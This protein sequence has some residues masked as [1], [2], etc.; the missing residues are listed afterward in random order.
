M[1]ARH[2]R[3]AASLLPGPHRQALPGDGALRVE[4]WYPDRLPREA[5]PTT[6]LFAGVWLV[7]FLSAAASV[8]VGRLAANDPGP[9]LLVAAGAAAFVT[10]YL[11]AFIVPRPLRTL[12]LSGREAP[13]WLNTV[14]YTL[15]LL[16]CLALMSPWMGP[17]V[18]AAVPYLTAVWVFPHSMRLGVPVAALFVALGLAAVGLLAPVADRGWLV[19]PVVLPAV[20]IILMRWA[21][22]RDEQ[23]GQTHRHLALAQQRER[24]SLDLHDIL[25]HSL[26]TINVKAQLVQRLMDADPARAKAEAAEVVALSR[27]ALVEARAAVAD[28][29]VP[30]LGAQLSTSVAA[31]RDAGIEVTAPPHGAVAEVPADRRELAAWFL[32]EAATN[33]LRHA[34][35]AGVVVGLDAH[36]ACVA[37]DGVGLPEHVLAGAGLR[38]LRARAA[39][40]GARV[41]AT[42]GTNETGTRVTL[43]WTDEHDEEGA[44]A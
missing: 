29:A 2:D 20:I 23:H 14:G 3:R 4:D 12:P 9:A 32:R 19:M 34:G 38:T 13:R 33:V 7:F 24:L 43:L 30:E 28:L 10:V 31:L 16:A 41:E 15:A 39:E 25:G 37:D 42:A 27:T 6:L 1:S 40:A 26:T 22:G 36:G 17:G 8:V 44:R 21:T 18:I 35:A 5:W 11:R